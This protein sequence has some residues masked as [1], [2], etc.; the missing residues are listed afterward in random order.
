MWRYLILVLFLGFL[1]GW[2]VLR[3]NPSPVFV[4]GVV[5]QPVDLIPGQG[6]NSLV[7]KTLERLLFRSLFAY[8]AKGEIVPDLADSYEVSADGKTYT[9]ILKDAFWRDGRA[10]SSADV[11]FTFTRD[12]SFSDV[13]IK[14]E[15]EK[16]IRFVLKE[17]LAPFLSILTRPIAP[18]NFR[19]LR[20]E[21][22][23]NSNFAIKDVVQEGETVQ[24]MRLQNGGEGRV[25]TLYF[26]FYQKEEDLLRAAA[27]GEVDALSSQSFSNQ[28][29]ASNQTPIFD[30]YFALFFNLEGENRL[31]RNKSFRKA[32]SAKTP[33]PKGGTSVNGPFSGTWAEGSF[34]FPRF[35]AKSSGKFTGT[36]SITVAN[37]NGFS[38]FAKQ[39]ADS[40]RRNLGVTVKVRAVNPA[41]IDAILTK[42]DFDAII[43]G[44]NVE[45]DPDR[46]NIW[47]SSKKDFPG[48]NISGYADPRADRALEEGRKVR[49][50]SIRKSHYANFQRL[51]FEDNPAILLYHSDFSYWV[52]RKFAGVDL[53]P[54]FSP[55]ERFWNFGEWRLSSETL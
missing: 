34:K 52:S 14:Q 7:D 4:E 9:I 18:A 48:Q 20:F 42:R 43:L 37:S 16:E 24:E 10:V 55:E 54:V 40:W 30:H 8:N 3:F 5:G 36:I 12:P 39:V 53:A 46:Y 23:G 49:K 28:S 33:L 2:F 38:D 32:A 35:S 22:L 1:G 31:V 17:P 13:T 15:G 45:R 29:F 11:A 41:E 50:V 27:A 6:P 19:N 25:K 21:L 51:F 26:K 47:H 44:Q